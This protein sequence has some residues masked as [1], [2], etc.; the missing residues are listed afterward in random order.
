MSKRL[1]IL[2]VGNDPHII[3]GVQNY[4]RPLAKTFAQ[5]G[6]HIHYF[7]S[8]VSTDSYNWFFKPYLRFNRKDFPFECAELVN[9]PNWKINFNDLSNDIHNR[10]TERIFEKYINRIRPDIMHVHSRHGLPASIIDIAAQNGIKAFNTIHIYGML[11]PKRVMV[12]KEGNICNGP[13]DL[14]KCTSCCV[15]PSYNR[16]KLRAR[17]ASVHPHLPKQLFKIKNVIRGKKD[18]PRTTGKSPLM[19][20]VDEKKLNALRFRLKNMIDLMNRRVTQNICVSTDVKNT[21]HRFGVQEDKLLVQHIGSVIAEFQKSDFHALHTPLV[22]GNI[23]GV[24]HYKGTQVLL[25]AVHQVKNKDFVVKIFGKYDPKYRDDIMRGKE[26]LPVEF[27]GRYETGELSSILKQIDI[28]VLPS[29]CKDTAPQTIFESFSARIPII[30]SDIGG[31]PDFIQDDRNGRLF[32]AGDSRDLAEKI[33]DI[34]LDPEKINAF[35]RNIPRLKT[36]KENADELIDLYVQSFK[37][38]E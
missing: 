9:S 7:Y 8:G 26:E 18:R 32:R 1:K 31:F 2:I 5:I 15:E 28:M 11:C 23:G 17:L 21:L 19:P 36:I 33:D 38:N 6:H 27:V 37:M 14:M 30:A 16:A 3:G 22:I 12:D 13:F 4:T 34:L 35:A 20:E 29:I 24:A 10:K 25:D